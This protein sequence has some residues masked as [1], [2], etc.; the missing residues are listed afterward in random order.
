MVACVAAAAHA[1][2]EQSGSSAAGGGVAPAEWQSY[3]GVPAANEPSSRV[4]VPT[5]SLPKALTVPKP[6]RQLYREAEGEGGEFE[7]YQ[8]DRKRAK[9][10]DGV[11][12]SVL[13]V[14]TVD[15]GGVAWGVLV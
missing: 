12:A 4:Q 2:S 14:S 7:L 1:K 6:E 10:H 13:Q 11:A 8:H 3:G 15:H 9:V 5:L